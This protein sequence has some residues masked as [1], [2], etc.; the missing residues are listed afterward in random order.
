MGTATSSSWQGL[1]MIHGS[2]H[3]AGVPSTKK[4]TCDS[5]I[6]VCAVTG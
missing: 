5:P 1:S 6:A 2:M 4:L 3:E